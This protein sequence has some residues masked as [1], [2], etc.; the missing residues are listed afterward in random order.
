MRPDKLVKC[1]D[2]IAGF[3]RRRKVTLR[4]IESLTGLFNFACTAVI[5]GR[6]FLWYLVDLT[7][8]I[9]SPHFLI[10]LTRGVEDLKSGS[11]FCLAVPVAPFFLSV[12]LANSHHLKLYT[13]ASGAIS[14]EAVFGRHWCNGE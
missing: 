9:H 11:N 8:G 3:L 6:G 14:F 10:R 1:L 2:L 12:D 7:I 4:E 13:N 5:P